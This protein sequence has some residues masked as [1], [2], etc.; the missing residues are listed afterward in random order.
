M[1]KMGGPLKVRSEPE[2]PQPLGTERC[3]AEEFR[4]FVDANYGSNMLYG[5]N[6]GGYREK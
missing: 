4:F 3:H 6:T 5:D 2:G 1:I